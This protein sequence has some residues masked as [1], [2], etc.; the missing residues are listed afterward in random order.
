MLLH[1]CIGLSLADFIIILLN[2]L[3]NILYFNDYFS[4][5]FKITLFK[6][7]GGN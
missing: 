4:K 3:I 6:F 2:F 5:Y 1:I 7:K